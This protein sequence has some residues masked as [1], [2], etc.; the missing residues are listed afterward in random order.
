MAE[1]LSAPAR[2]VWVLA[3]A[4]LIGA[5]LAPLTAPADAVAQRPAIA[6]DPAARK[7]QQAQL[8]ERLD[9]VR[10][11]QRQIEAERS[12]LDGERG[13]LLGN[14]RSAELAMSH[15]RREVLVLEGQLVQQQDQLS[16]L[17][18]ERGAVQARVAAEQAA[19]DALLRALYV[20]G[21]HYAARV[22]LAQD[23][24]VALRPALVYAHYLRNARAARIAQL[25]K[26][27]VQL[28]TLDQAVAATTAELEQRRAALDAELAQLA[29]A[30]ADRARVLQ[31]LEAS[32]A[33]QAQ[34]LAE[35]A[36]DAR[37]LDGLLARLADA[38]ADVPAQLAGQ[39]AFASLR[40]RLPWPAQGAVSR[41]FGAAGSRQGLTIGATS[42]AKVQAVAHGRVAYA[43]WMR[44]YGLLAIIDHGDGFMS[45]YANNRSLLTQVGDWVEGGQ[46]IAEAGGDAGASGI[47]FELRRRGQA[48]EPTAWLERR[49]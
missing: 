15:A 8:R 39:A 49:R 3:T 13:R 37:A 5:S 46:A 34:Q 23:S 44:G 25:G 9:A 36:K 7:A 47:Y 12:A 6:L 24:A 14:L 42:G 26:A 4:L 38:I 28:A 16:E 27:M 17:N 19:V 40:G 43:D 41:G 10:A 45:L 21:R 11:E 32:L 1:H 18:A 33:D 29:T 48:I 31:A 35:L 2:G 22:L 20:S 30:N